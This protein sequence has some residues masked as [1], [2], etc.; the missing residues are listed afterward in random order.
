MNKKSLF[1]GW[2]LVAALAVQAQWTAPVVPGE[3]LGTLNSTDIVYI[4]NVEADA[5]VMYGMT[6]NTQACAAR[7]TNGDYTASTP[8]QSYVFSTTDGRLR[9]RNKEKGGSYYIACPS[10]K[11]GDVVIN[12]NTNPYFTY[13]EVEEGSRV[14]TL[15]NE[16][17]EKMLDVSWTYG[18]HLT[19]TDGTGQT[20]WAF[21]KE[22][23]VTNGKYALYKSRKQLYAVYEAVVAAGK[24]D[25]HAAALDEALAAYT[26]AN[27]T[28]ESL[29]AAARKLFGSVCVDITEPLEVSFM[30]DNADMVGSAS[31]APWHNGS[32]AF[33]WEE[34]EVYHATFTLEQEATLPLGTYD[35]GFHSLYREDGSGSA[36]TLT[37]TTNKGKYT[38]KT[39]LMG[40]IDYAVTNA[41]DNNWVS[42]NGTI[43][44]NGMQSCGQALAHGDAMAWARD[45]VVDAAGNMSIKYAVTSSAQW[46]NWQ[47]FRL[48]YKGLSRD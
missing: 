24:V 16:A 29:K 17:Y 13:A 9:M 48:V 18:G 47:G 44:P 36:P 14:Y 45:I 30:L 46:V 43:E 39:P 12:K 33:G 38:G 32:P 1:L 31:A 10:D 21:I 20:T 11:A 37:V 3:D 28:E 42:R 41:T 34:F 6:S 23:N 15:T 8:N 7:L 5:F 26:D 35:L 4:Y 27:A 40:T 19:L 2:C 25:V 22:S